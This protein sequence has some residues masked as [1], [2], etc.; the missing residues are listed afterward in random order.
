M[1]DEKQSTEGA[2]TVDDGDTHGE[3]IPIEN[4]HFSVLAIVQEAKQRFKE[5]T[6]KE[7]KYLYAPE[8]LCWM[9]DHA[10]K[11]KILAAG[12][13]VPKD[14]AVV[15]IFGMEI[16]SVLGACTTLTAEPLHEVTEKL[17]AINAPH[18]STLQ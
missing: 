1:T 6:G 5:K 2:L 13:A 7:A 4:L 10:I 16:H 11:A 14:A 18:P 3:Q 8:A 15:G 12:E 17:P 9:I